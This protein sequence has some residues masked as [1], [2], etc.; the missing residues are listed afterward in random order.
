MSKRLGMLT[1][2]SNTVLEPVTQQL[3]SGHENDVT[4]HFSRFR[5][6]TVSADA[7]SDHQFDP[8]P[9]LEAAQLL[10]DA[11]VDVITWNG[12]SGA[13]TGLDRDHAL[14][15]QIEAGTGVPATTATLSLIELLER[16]GAR[17]YALVVP[18]VDAVV[19]RIK[20]NFASAGFECVGATNESITDN[21]AFSQIR[22]E[23]IEDRVRELA[24]TQPEAVVIHCTNLNGAAA[25]GELARELGIP[26]LD[27]VVVAL[28]G[29][30]ER[31]G[32]HVELPGFSV[33][34]EAAH[35]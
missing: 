28:W 25:A 27:S 29:A 35:V 30:L 11:R 14:V 6:T 5:V 4:A 7:A 22:P 10:A 17:R 26:V 24:R 8:A 9:M 15:S 13:W 23:T 21:F 1:P 19:D 2:S 18:Y 32:M 31:V 20:E 16:L 12:T 3:L 34:A 33:A